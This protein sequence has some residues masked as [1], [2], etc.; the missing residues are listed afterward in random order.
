[1]KVILSSGAM[2]CD[3]VPPF[4]DIKNKPKKKKKGEKLRR[5]NPLRSYETL[6]SLHRFK[7]N[8]D[9]MTWWETSRAA[10]LW[11]RGGWWGVFDI[12]LGG[13]CQILE[14][15]SLTLTLPRFFLDSQTTFYVTNAKSICWFTF[16]ISWRMRLSARAHF[17]K[18]FLN[19]MI[20]GGSTSA[21]V[22]K[23]ILVGSWRAVFII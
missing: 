12:G 9:Q 22:P 13:K 1:M 20:Q 4:V 15:F 21:R 18:R 3:T 10:R 2:G 7:W 23:C 11:A 8:Q 14:R 5:Q 17:H 6:F 19:L 16:L